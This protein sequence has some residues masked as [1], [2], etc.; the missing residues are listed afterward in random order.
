M[1]RLYYST[2]ARKAFFAVIVTGSSGLYASHH[3]VQSEIHP[4]SSSTTPIPPPLKVVPPTSP[5]SV[6]KPLLPLYTDEEVSSNVGNA[7]GPVWV[8]Y[9]GGVYDITDFISSHPGG[10]IILQAAGK[11]LEPF[12]NLYAQHDEEFV[13]Q[14]LEEYRIG[15]LEEKENSMQISNG[16]DPYGD[17]PWRRLAGKGLVVRSQKPFNAEP[18]LDLLVQ[19]EITPTDLFY[20]RNHLPVPPQVSIESYRLKILDLDGSEIGSFSMEQLKALPKHEIIATI[21]CAGNRRDEMRS[22]KEV[23]GGNW[24]AGAI[25]NAK[26]GGVKLVDI[27]ESSKISAANH[28]CFE[29]LDVDPISKNSYGASIPADLVEDILV[30][31]EMN[32]EMLSR[33]H[34]FPI[35]IVTPG[36]IG[37]RSVKW[38]DSIQLSKTESPSHWQQKDYKSFS[39]DIDWDNISEENWA[40]SPAI[41]EAPVTSVICTAEKMKDHIKMNGYAWSGGGKE[42]IRVDVSCDGGKNWKEASLKPKVMQ[43]SK[44]GWTLWEA[45]VLVPSDL[46]NPQLVCKA[47]DTANNT[48][49]ERLESIW[50]LRGL[51]NNAWYRLDRSEISQDA[52]STL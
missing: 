7:G 1:Q 35:R 47:V 41:Q 50:N 3:R 10:S 27:I 33:D 44:Y 25:G 18:Q 49:P 13:L 42:I 20:V 16:D 26:W 6:Q 17:E 32:G 12:W 38:V 24:G 43:P 4:A 22:V 40:N 14:L 39:P 9:R 23:R 8:S 30:V 29:G 28:V 36:I 45:S 51:L 34:G 5:T 31:Y 37:A 2:G 19:H 46:E 21:Q 48:Q 11:P 52:G 15:D